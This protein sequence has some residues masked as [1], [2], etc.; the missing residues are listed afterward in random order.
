LHRH[1]IC[2]NQDAEMAKLTFLAGLSAL[3][4]A[5]CAPLEY[6]PNPVP[7]HPRGTRLDAVPPVAVYPPPPPIAP[8]AAAPAPVAS[9][10]AYRPGSG[11]VESIAL[12]R[13]GPVTSAAAGGSVAAPLDAIGYQLGVRMDDGTVQTIVQDNRHFMVGDRVEL[14]NDGHVIRR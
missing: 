14:T 9:A 13:T 12:V 1:G 8:S 7:E 6:E 10:P 3:A 2:L 11:M 5:A 4:L